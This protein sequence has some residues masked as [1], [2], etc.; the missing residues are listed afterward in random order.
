[1]ALA[2]QAKP[3]LERRPTPDGEDNPNHGAFPTFSAG[4]QRKFL[5]GC[6]R[7]DEAGVEAVFRG[8]LGA[9]AR[10]LCGAR[11]VSA[12]EEPAA[13]VAAAENPLLA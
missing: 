4:G 1:M 7:A 13:A 12:A 3:I 5:G 8:R 9:A 10:P 11:G 2:S 6:V